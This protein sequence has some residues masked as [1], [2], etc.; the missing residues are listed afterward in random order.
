MEQQCQSPCLSSDIQRPGRLKLT[1]TPDL[2]KISCIKYAHDPVPKAS[3][4][5]SPKDIPFPQRETN[6]QNKKHAIRLRP[7]QSNLPYRCTLDAAHESSFWR[8]GLEASNRLIEL[9]ADDRSITDIVVGKG[10]TMARLAQREL[11]PGFEHR[12]CKAT[13]YMYPFCDEERTK[14]LATSM[15]MMFLFDGKE[16]LYRFCRPRI[17]DPKLQT[18]ARRRLKAL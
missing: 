15:V 13:S 10:E 4:F 3:S 11:R 1:A 14:L 18:K 6:H 7:R 16:V 2:G 17:T 8:S 12:F 5:L 9:L